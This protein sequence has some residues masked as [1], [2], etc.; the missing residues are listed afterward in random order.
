MMGNEAASVGTPAL[1]SDVRYECTNSPGDPFTYELKIAQPQPSSENME[2]LRAPSRPAKPPNN[3]GDSFKYEFI[4]VD[5]PAYESDDTDNL[6][7]CG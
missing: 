4:D 7:I 3:D 1:T 5:N 6:I 2:V